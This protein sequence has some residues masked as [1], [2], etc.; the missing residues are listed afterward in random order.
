GMQYEVRPG[1]EGAFEGGF[2]S[3]EEALKKE[4]Q[5]HKLTRLFKDVFKPQSYMIYSEWETFADFQKFMV[6]PE[7]KAAT[8]WGKEEILMGRPK[9]TIL[10]HEEDMGGP[11]S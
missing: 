7:F 5:G 6:S 11:P 8:T 9:H 3:V 1:K 10:K 4:W 2:K